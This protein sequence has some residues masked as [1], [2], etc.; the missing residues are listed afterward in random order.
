MDIGSGS[1]ILSM[2]AANA[3]AKHVYA[4]EASSMSNFS[5]ILIQS[6]YSKEQNVVITHILL[7]NSEIRL[8]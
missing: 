8:L 5:K 6:N 4:I 1:G 3:G 7:I 2:F